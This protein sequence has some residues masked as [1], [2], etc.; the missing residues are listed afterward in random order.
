MFCHEF[1]V[2]ELG[3]LCGI[4]GMDFL[5]NNDV[6]ILI[7][8]CLMMIGC[9]HIKLE[10][11]TTPKCARVKVAKNIVIPPDS[12]F[13]RG[14][15]GR[16]LDESVSNLF[17]PFKFLNQKGLLAARTLVRPDK[18]YLSDIS[19]KSVRISKYGFCIAG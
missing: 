14:Y 9:K 11:E 16:Y 8:R 2:T 13:V 6:T 10:R 12:D 15:A 3:D 1:I 17:E 4:L 19:D 18:I 7:S 5:Q